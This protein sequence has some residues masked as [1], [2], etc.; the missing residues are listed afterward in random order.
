ME[1]QHQADTSRHT[2]ILIATYFPNQRQN[3]NRQ[4]KVIAGNCKAW[5]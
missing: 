4:M 1:A 2:L 5:T 3:D